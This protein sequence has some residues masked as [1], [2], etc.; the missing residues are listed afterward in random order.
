M[1]LGVILEVISGMDRG[2]LNA[3]GKPLSAGASSLRRALS[4]SGAV[5]AA[6]SCSWSI[7]RTPKQER[8]GDRTGISTTGRGADSAPSTLVKPMSRRKCWPR[9]LVVR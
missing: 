4:L 2:N 7:A 5:S 9:S 8:S 6:A 3:Y 1:D